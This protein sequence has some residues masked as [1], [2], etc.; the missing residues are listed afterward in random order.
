MS[1]SISSTVLGTFVKLS[2][3][4]FVTKT[5]SSILT[6]HMSMFASSLA[7]FKNLAKVSSFKALVMRYLFR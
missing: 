2:L 1:A 5:L 6:P 4:S 7:A 3:P